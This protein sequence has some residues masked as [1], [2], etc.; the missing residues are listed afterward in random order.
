MFIVRF[1]EVEQTSHQL[2]LALML[3]LVEEEV[4]GR[5]GEW[6]AMQNGQ[7]A[8]RWGKEEGYLVYAGQKVAVQRPRLRDPKSNRE[9]S[10]ETW[11]AFSHPARMEQSVSNQILRRISYRDYAGAVQTVYDGYGNRKSS[12]S[13]QWKAASAQ[14]LRQLMERPLGDLDLLAILLDARKSRESP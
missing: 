5:A 13:R 8:V 12:V 11:Q 14:Q 7:T 9:L 4:R 6:H 10:L 3:R 1:L 2:G